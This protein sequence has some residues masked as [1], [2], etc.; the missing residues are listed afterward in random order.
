MSFQKDDII[1]VDSVKC[2][3]KTLEHLELFG[4]KN[5]QELPNIWDFLSKIEEKDGKYTFQAVP[6]PEL[7]NVQKQAAE[8]KNYFAGLISDCLQDQ[9]EREEES[10]QLM[11]KLCLLLDW[12]G[13]VKLTSQMI[14]YLMFLI[15]LMC[16]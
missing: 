6:L 14:S 2:M 7:E 3:E 1:P 11:K 8:K 15:F 10:I 16:R 4:K 9:L 5:F 12:V 13:R